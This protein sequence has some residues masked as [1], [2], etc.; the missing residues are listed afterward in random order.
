MRWRKLGQVFDPRAHREWAGSH[1]QV[2]TV[3]VL[4]D[5]LRVYYADRHADGRSF[6]TF[7][8]VDRDD[9]TRVLYCHRVPVLG[10]GAP[11]TFDDEGVMPAFALEHEGRIRLYYSGWNRRVSV[12]Y[13]NATGLAVSDDGGVTFVRAFDGPLLDRTPEE[14]Y[15]AVTPWV[16]REPR[17]GGGYAWRAWYISGLRWVPVDGRLEPVYVIKHALSDDGIRWQRPN[18]Q[19]VAQ[20]HELEAFSHPSVW[21]DGDTWHMWY[22][23]RH[24]R[25]YRTGPG[26]YRIGYAR[27][28]DGIGFERDDAAAGIDVSE[29]G[30][31]DTMICYPA[32]VPVGDRVFLFY[33]GNAFGQT[34]IGVAVLERDARDDRPRRGE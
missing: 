9:P 18:L 10:W 31:D 5:R 23:H 13:H 29:E 1:A 2:P 33:N 22:C 15:L 25:D 34:G 8:D 28:S 30:W 6:P 19:C 7:I 12:P 11:G 16:L 20:Q 17:A 24:S 21:R 27:S 32:V 26:A 3:L 4:A 14:P